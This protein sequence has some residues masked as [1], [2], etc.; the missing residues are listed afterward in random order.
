MRVSKGRDELLKP[1]LNRVAQLLHRV[2]SGEPRAVHL[3]RVASRRLRELLPLLE[4]DASQSRKLSRRLRKVTRTLGR[5]RELDVLSQLA[6][7]SPDA[8]RRERRALALVAREVEAERTKAVSRARTS[9][10]ASDLKR[11]TRKLERVAKS[12]G[13]DDRTLA[14]RRAWH[15]ALDARAARRADALREVISAAGAMYLS[16][17]LHDVRI[18]LKKLRYTVELVAE[19]RGGMDGDLRTLKRAQDA[20]GRLHDVQTLVDRLRGIQAHLDPSAEGA[21]RDLDAL[22][23]MLEHECRRLHA[24]YVGGRESLG[25]VCERL[26]AHAATPRASARRRAG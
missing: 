7:A 13:H 8:G 18:A 21:R 11:I 3:A 22:L 14:H 17:R 20:L 15:W 19:V 1:R 23:E 26:A 12:L 6:A 10:V 4:L 25:V 5:V 2:A 16:E 24:R 9:K